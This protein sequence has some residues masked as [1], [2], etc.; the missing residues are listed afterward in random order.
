LKFGPFTDLIRRALP[1]R[2]VGFGR[3]FSVKLAGLWAIEG[4]LPSIFGN[5]KRF[6]WLIKLT[7][8]GEAAKRDAY[9]ID[10]SG[11]RLGSQIRL[12]PA[13]VASGARVFAALILRNP[14]HVGR[15]VP[16]CKI[17]ISL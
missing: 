6:K 17:G 9:H 11:A 5:G 4:N 1:P 14:S 13:Q 7:G 8:K 10:R 16:T 12:R 2:R 15:F 3:S